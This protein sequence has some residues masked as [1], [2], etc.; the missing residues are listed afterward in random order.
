MQ[1]L[2]KEINEMLV[3]YAD[4]RLPPSESGKV[5]GHLAKCRRCRSILKALHRSIELASVIWEDG[6]AETELI[7][8]PAPHKAKQRHWLR[9]AAVAASILLLITGYIIWHTPA[10]PT[11]PQPTFAEIERR[12]SE[13]ASAARLLAA[14]DMLAQY[15]DAETI[16][17]RQYRYI[18][19]TYPET[20][21]AAK[22]KL[23]IQ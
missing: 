20:P 10:T 8:I 21:A 7:H 17:N 14:A 23:Q 9:Y 6:L 12:I 15:P 11:E 1:K 5:S 4:G 19:E 13:S 18:A 16:V 3:D 2:C 22:A